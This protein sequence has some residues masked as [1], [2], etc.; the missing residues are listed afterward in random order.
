MSALEEMAREQL[1]QII[2]RTELRA[3]QQFIHAN[4]LAPYGAEAK[5]AQRDLAQMLTG[6]AKLKGMLT[7]FSEPTSIRQASPSTSATGTDAPISA[8]SSAQ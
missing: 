7:K 5:R 4:S 3:G 1:R 8:T 2:A 6:L